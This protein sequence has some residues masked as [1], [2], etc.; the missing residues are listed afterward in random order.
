MSDETTYEALM[1]Q[2]SETV[3][4]LERGDLG[5]EQALALFEQ[6]VRLSNVAQ[7]RLAGLEGRI[8]KL[9]EDGSVEAIE[10]TN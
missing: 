9:L 7:K 8:E 10:E 6:G 3:D 2:L 5:I 1:E 4:R